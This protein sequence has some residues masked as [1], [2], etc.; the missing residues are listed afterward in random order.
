M[1]SRL[2]APLALV[3]ATVAVVACGTRPGPGAPVGIGAGAASGASSASASASVAE[4][5]GKPLDFALDPL[6]RDPDHI[7]ESLALRG[8][9]AVVIVVTTYDFGSQKLLRVL[10]PTLRT[11]PADATCLLVAKQPISD[12]ILVQTF[13]DTEPT[14]CR[15]AIADPA[16]GHLGDLGK[17]NIVPAVLVLR[18]DGSLADAGAGEI[19]PEEL[20]GA[21]ERAKR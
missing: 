21:L 7:D 8:K 2:V 1:L 12:R 11:L 3:V 9:R 5:H 16:R 6:D 17:V 10:A 4:A 15:R 19:T 13:L 14:P 18:A 20:A